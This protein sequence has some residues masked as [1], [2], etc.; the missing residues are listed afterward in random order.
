MSMSD[1]SQ[2]TI[3]SPT[4]AVHDTIS[5]NGSSGHCSP[6]LSRV[7]PHFVHCLLPSSQNVPE[8]H[9]AINDSV[10]CTPHWTP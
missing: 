1:H 7:R 4:P 10:Y 3:L 6:L 5:N 8:I 9:L 2:G